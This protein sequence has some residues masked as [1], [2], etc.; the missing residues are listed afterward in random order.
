MIFVLYIPAPSGLGMCIFRKIL[1][2]HGITIMYVFTCLAI[3]QIVDVYFLAVVLVIYRTVLLSTIQ[4]AQG[5]VRESER[6]KDDGRL[7]VSH[8][9][10]LSLHPNDVIFRWWRPQRSSLEQKLLLL[11]Y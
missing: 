10:T 6:L 7:D 11:H 3:L 9:Q 4:G 1:C 2:G 8:V 5:K